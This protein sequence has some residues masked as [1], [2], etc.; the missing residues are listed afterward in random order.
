[1]KAKDL[2]TDYYEIESP[3]QLEALLNNLKNQFIDRGLLKE[4]SGEISISEI[5]GRI[6]GKRTLPD[7][8]SVEFETI[9][10]KA[11]YVLNCDTYHGGGIFK[12]I[13]SD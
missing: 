10:G 3:A 5:L 12:K 13:S 11:K 6:R 4:L 8:L 7:I 2:L 1:M 9:P